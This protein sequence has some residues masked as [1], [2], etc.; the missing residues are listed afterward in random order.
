MI[1]KSQNLSTY[2]KAIPGNV[3]TWY[4]Q[5]ASAE[6]LSILSSTLED[7]VSGCF[8]FCSPHGKRGDVGTCVGSGH[9]DALWS[10]KGPQGPQGPQ[11]TSVLST[12]PMS[13]T[14]GLHGP[15]HTTEVDPTVALGC[16]LGTSA[17]LQES[18]AISL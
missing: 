4:A 12:N 11:C 17:A 9:F 14:H 18:A 6:R 7:G 10:G 13:W 2:P 8:W 16:P 3:Q 15:R 1:N 5:E